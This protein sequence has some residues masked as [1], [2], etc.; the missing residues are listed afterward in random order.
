M[1]SAAEPPGQ[2]AEYL[3]E[4]TRI[5]AAQQELLARRRRRIEELERQV[6]RLSRENAGL[7]E[8]HRR[9][10]AA[11][12]RRPDPG[13]GPQPLGAIP[14]LG[15]RRD[16]S[17]GE[18][19]RSVRS[20]LETGSSLSTDRY[21][22]EG[23][24]PSSETGTSLDSPSAYHQGPSAPGSGLGPDHSEHTPGGAYGLYAG[25]PGQQ[26]T[27]RPK[28]Q[29]STSIL[30]KQ[31]EEE[32]IKRSRSLSESYELSSDLQDK[33][34][35]MLERKY[36]GRLVTRHAARTIQTAFR[37]YQMNKNFERLRSSMSENRM[38]R[39]IVLSNMRMQF[40]FEGPE[41]VHSSYF[42]GKQVSVTD[43]GTP[44]E[45][46]VPAECRDLGPPPALQAP[47]PAGD[48]ADAI[49]ELEDAF[50]RQVKSLAESIDDALNCRSLHT[51]GAPA[52]DV[53]RT[54]D[55]EPSPALHGAEHRQL[56]EMTASYSD[57]TLY[58]DEE[59]LSP[60]LPPMQAGRR[61][62]SAESDLRLRPGG[63]AQDYWALA[64]KDDKGDTD[65]S[66]RSTPSLGP[67]EPR[68]R[69]EHLPLLTIEPPSDSSVDLSDRSDRSSLKRQSAYERGLGGPQGSPKHGPHGPPRGLPREE[70]EP[71]ARAPRPLDGH[72]A[73]NGSANRQSKSESDYSDGDN[74]S[75]NSTSNSNDTINCSSE[76]SSRD[77]LR[78]QTLS[79][80]TYHKET[81]N[82]WDSPTFS[83]DV[84]RRRH[85]RIG[86]N[87]FNKKPE[88]GVQYL[89]E[90]GFVP[91]T[92]VGVA[93][94]LLQR[95][96]LSRQMIGEFLGNRQKQFNRDVLDCVVDEMDFSAME[97]DEALRKFQA[98]IRVQG[99]AQKV[100][101]L[102]EA[103]SQ[104]Y[105][106]C[107]PGVVRQFRNPDTIFI[108]AFAI[109]LLNTDM[110]SPNVK[111]ERKMKLEDFVKN[112]RGVDDGEDIPREMLIGIYERI[113]KREL[114]TNE[115][116][117]SQ[118]QKVEKLIVGK[119]PIG[120]LHHGLGCVLSLPHRRLVCYCRLFE[121]PDPNKPQKLGLHQREIFLFNDLLVVTKIFQKKK[122]SV[123]Y[124]FRQS[125][126]LYGMQ[127]LLFENQY[128]PN[129]IRLT[130]AVPGADIKVLINFNAPNPQD[131]KKFTD[132]LRESIAEV[133]EMEKHRIETELEKQKGVVRPSMSQCSSLKKEPGGGTLSRACLDDSYASGEGLKRSALS[134][135]LRDLS[136]AG[137][138]H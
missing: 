72:L 56:D 75:L 128:Y 70:P 55:A 40:S 98:H 18:S 100:E 28:L 114:E 4:L 21:S 42:E 46:L 12:A 41:K 117:V 97:L 74:D 68:L 16:K 43:K 119:K 109:I 79:K 22:V 49:T 111:P 112:L 126:S 84:I 125:F 121:V 113:R 13:P 59:E 64:H 19:S 44:L 131:R 138:H 123:T 76:S 17:E 104:R 101:R 107:N 120:S 92:P 132:D 124:S 15:G 81:R 82:S 38:S 39:R 9:H 65:T 89:I 115:D 91:D 102:I 34:V 48:F 93:H 31:A 130:S 136:E 116:H 71:R 110:Y 53:G 23:E 54:R 26:R 73:I 45:A 61:P 52:P 62:S 47:A 122:N 24:A 80:Q 20:S 96:G 88:K 50:S 118:V 87:L 29:H 2:A 86:L 85:Y 90:R 35:E 58:I 94:F 83:N 60:P 10:L 25:P 137:V 78:E 69:G 63:A 105:C 37:Q 108:L 103:F 1:A 129:G 32:A 36:G 3:Q 127:V 27:R 5:V 135:S 11:C 8:R 67:Q 66:C 33:Q 14:E 7:L 95:K 6:A 30:R 77:S 133:Q 134:S 106:I 99:E 51:E 57:V